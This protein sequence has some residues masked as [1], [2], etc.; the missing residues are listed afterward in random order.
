MTNPANARRILKR[1]PNLVINIRVAKPGKWKNLEPMLNRD[2]RVYED[3]A[4]LFEEMPSRFMIGT[5]T[6]FMRGDFVPAD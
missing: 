6:K 4:R 1:Y 5:D 2:G 3:W